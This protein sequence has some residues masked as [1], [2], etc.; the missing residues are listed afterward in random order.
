[1]CDAGQEGIISKRADA[2]YRGARTK[3]WLKIKCT[4]RQEFVIVGWTPSESK[5][6]ALRALL[7]AVHE[8]EKLRYAGKTGTG[9]SMAT[10][11][12]LREKLGRIEVK[13]APV[14]EP[15]SETRGAHWGT[16]ALVAEVAFAE[17]TSEGVVRHASFLGLREDKPAEDRSEEHTSALQS[18]M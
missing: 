11:Q 14:E 3:N 8:D 6:R 1:M 17:F 2:P 16:P 9:F 5:G 13:K 15:R 12:D 4:N 7:L 18:L 10:L